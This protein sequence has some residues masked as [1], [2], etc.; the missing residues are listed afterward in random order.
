MNK[1]NIKKYRDGI[2]MLVIVIV[3]RRT[4]YG[5]SE[6]RKNQV[7]R[8]IQKQRKKLGG[9]F[10]RPNVTQKGKDLE[11]LCSEIIRNEMCLK[12]Q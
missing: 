10:T 2:M 4:N 6:N 3:R 8:I 12:F 1:R 7:R 5:R 9:L 11:T